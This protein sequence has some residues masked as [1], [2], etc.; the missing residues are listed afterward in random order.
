MIRKQS[1]IFL[2]I[3]LLLALP[4]CATAEQ[5]SAPAFASASYV[6]PGGRII[7][8]VEVDFDGREI[9]CLSGSDVFLMPATSKNSR[10]VKA[11]F[12]RTD[13]G[14]VIQPI[15][16]DADATRGSAAARLYPE[17][18]SAKCDRD[19]RFY[20]SNIAPGEYF[21]MTA[22]ILR[23]LGG[24]PTRFGD[25]VLH[26]DDEARISLMDRVTIQPSKSTRAVL[27]YRDS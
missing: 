16:G 5:A 20:F 24:L 7:G 9:G 23:G 15:E 27:E 11:A 4:A 18:I 10:Q 3:P 13:E 14:A 19:G 2:A 26:E 21:L 1:H 8:N 22:L 17:A 25:L 6:G 12:G